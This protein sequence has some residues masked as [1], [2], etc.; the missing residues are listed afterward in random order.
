MTGNRGQIGESSRQD[1][2]EATAMDFLDQAASA[3]QQPQKPKEYSAELDALVS[4]LMQQVIREADQKPNP[5]AE[6]DNIDD[7]LAEF[8]PHQDEPLTVGSKD[9]APNSAPGSKNTANTVLIDEPFSHQGTSTL[10]LKPPAAE[11]P[12]QINTLPQKTPIFASTSAN[13]RKFPILIAAIAGLLAVVGVAA[14]LFINPTS[15]KSQQA[16]AQPLAADAVTPS[17]ESKMSEA[18]S[19]SV[20]PM[21][22]TAVVPVPSSNRP[23]GTEASKRVSVVRKSDAKVSDGTNEK[24]ASG[25]DASSVPQAKVEMPAPVVAAPPVFANNTPPPEKPA[26]PAISETTKM[27]EAVAENR[28]AQNIPAVPKPVQAASGTPMSEAAAPPEPQRAIQAA[29]KNA[30]SAIPISRANP[31]YPELAIRART[32]ATVVLDVSI[33]SQGKVIKAT[34][35]SGPAI[36]HNEAIRAAMKW[37]YKPAS[38]DGTN[39]PSQSKITFNF[40]L[41]R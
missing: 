16:A 24:L 7:L 21:N 20:A 34:P 30:T 27:P 31:Q 12:A 35:L 40:N 9:P 28:A 15:D 18:H 32:S 41:T 4:D 25:N 1:R 5:T 29:P 11:M 33:D 37:R 36:F 6:P 38:I 22:Q 2:Q 8:L 23:S 13:K 3:V 19:N 39:V 17:I 26:T 14:Y 10:S